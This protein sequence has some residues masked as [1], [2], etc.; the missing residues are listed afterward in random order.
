M[1]M[2]LLLL[3]PYPIGI[4][5]TAFTR[6][7]HRFDRRSKCHDSGGNEF[8]AY[9]AR[10]GHSTFNAT[11]DRGS[12]TEKESDDASKTFRHFTRRIGGIA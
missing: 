4:S 8:D 7:S 2:R 3:R 11:G 6:Q 5:R 9:R 12:R 1:T 10:S